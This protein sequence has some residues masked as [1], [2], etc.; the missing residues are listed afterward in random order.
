MSRLYI[1]SA[2]ID[3]FLEVASAEKAKE[4]YNEIKKV[5]PEHSFTIFGAEDVT[6]LARS[7]RHLDP[8]HLTKSVSTF[9]ETLC[10]SPSPGKRT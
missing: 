10:T 7:H 5:V 2:S 1:V 4:A 6:S 8:S 9:M 3:E